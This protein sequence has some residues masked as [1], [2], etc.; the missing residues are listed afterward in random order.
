MRAA[1]NALAGADPHSLREC[2]D[3]EWFERYGRRIED[4][5]DGLHDLTALG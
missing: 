4:Q 2:A 1:L 3:P 5:R